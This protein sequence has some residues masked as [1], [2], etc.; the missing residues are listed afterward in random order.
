M[1]LIQVSDLL[2]FMQNKPS[3]KCGI[4]LEHVVLLLGGTLILKRISARVYVILLMGRP[5]KIPSRN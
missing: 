2:P 4:D 1:A 3:G 5:A